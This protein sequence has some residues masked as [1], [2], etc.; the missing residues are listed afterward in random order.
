MTPIDVVLSRAH[1]G[2]SFQKCFAIQVECQKC[3]H[4]SLGTD[5]ET[6]CWVLTV[7]SYAH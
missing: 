7:E 6:H 3:I 4:F 5:K 2:A 1:D